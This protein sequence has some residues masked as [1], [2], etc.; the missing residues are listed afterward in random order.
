MCRVWI[1]EQ[2]VTISLHSIYKYVPVIEKWKC[3]LR[4][5]NWNFKY[6]CG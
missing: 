2:I 3:L 6:T 4:G 1:S 5:T